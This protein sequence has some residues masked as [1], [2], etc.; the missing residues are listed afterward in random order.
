MATTVI[1]CFA[2]WP[3]NAVPRRRC[4]AR[5]WRSYATC[6]DL[7]PEIEVREGGDAVTARVKAGFFSTE[8]QRAE[9]LLAEIDYRFA[10]EGVTIRVKKIGEGV[11]FV[12]PLVEGSGKIV[13][14]NRYEKRSVFFLTGGF[15]A[16]EY[17][18]PL[19]EDLVITIV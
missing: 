8:R 7:A 11:R 18:F 4:S 2:E 14:E 19:G 6:L 12:L 1:A 5:S 16:E 10:P 13:T 3:E 15:A 17:T 9:G